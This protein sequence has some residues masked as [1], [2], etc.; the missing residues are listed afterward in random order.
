MK[1]C[2]LLSVLS[3][4]SATETPG[5]F[6][7]LSA[8]PLDRALSDVTGSIVS[9]LKNVKI[10]GHHDPLLQIDD[11][12][13]EDITIGSTAVSSSPVRAWKLV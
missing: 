5:A 13:F 12:G 2:L 8:A 4:A 9:E 10:P 7:S 6:F 1:S 3:R 11:L